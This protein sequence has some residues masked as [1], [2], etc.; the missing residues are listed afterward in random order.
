MVL[1]RAI[2]DVVE[3]KTTHIVEDVSEDTS[4][5]ALDDFGVSSIDA[6][7]RLLNSV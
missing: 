7:F 6:S 1:A 5:C 3:A 4:F 2:V